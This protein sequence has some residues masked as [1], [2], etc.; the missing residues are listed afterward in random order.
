MILDHTDNKATLQI[1]PWHKNHIRLN[2]WQYLKIKIW[3][4]KSL[5]ITIT[6]LAFRMSIQ[7]AVTSN[8]GAVGSGI[9]VDVLDWN[10]TTHTGIIK[11]SQSELII[12]WGSLVIYQ[13][14]MSGQPC[15]FDILDNSASLISLADNSRNDF[16]F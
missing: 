5:D 7:Q 10:E 14:S 2:Q 4:D 16:H 12:F 1:K 9:K 13:F 6:E 15:A 8:L 11:V 3:S